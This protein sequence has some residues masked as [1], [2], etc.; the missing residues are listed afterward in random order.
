VS[1]DTAVVLRRLISYERDHAREVAQLV[2]PVEDGALV[3][4]PEIDSIWSANYLEIQETRLDHRGLAEL[5]DRLLGPR[6]YRH[7]HVVPTEQDSAARLAPGFAELGWTVNRNVYM[8]LSRPPER[9]GAAAV[10]VSRKE[11]EAVR[12]AVRSR[13]PD[14]TP[15][16]IEQ[17]LAWDA[18]MDRSAAARWF[19]AFHDGRPAS[20]CV[21]YE[22][23]GVGQVE[24]VTTDPELEGRG[25]A[26]GVVLAA[27]RASREAGHE[28]TFIV[29]DADDWPWKLYERLGFDPVGESCTFVLKPEPPQSP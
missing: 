3:L 25:L 6:G 28:L 2:E 22:R 29:A 21:L 14:R 26:S 10:E 15:G 27:A 18:R 7:R 24:T 11:T 20:S 9:E 19:A 16:F 1:E 12:T 5:A 4:N 8:R 23:D 17:M 13:R